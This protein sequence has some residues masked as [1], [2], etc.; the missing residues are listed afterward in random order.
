ME[1]VE[2]Q[3]MSAPSSIWTARAVRAVVSKVTALNTDSI[4]RLSQSGVLSRLNGFDI[5][6][7]TTNSQGLALALLR[8]RG[9]LTARVLFIPMGVLPLEASP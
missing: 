5:V 4:A 1:L 2:E 6:V 7:A 3:D 8:A 9:H